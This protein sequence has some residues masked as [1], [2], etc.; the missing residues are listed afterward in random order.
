MAMRRGYAPTLRIPVAEPAS[1]FPKHFVGTWTRVY[2]DRIGPGAKETITGTATFVRDPNI[3]A[4]AEA[5][6]AI[7]CELESASVAWTV[8]GSRVESPCTTTYSG[9]GTDSSAV[10]PFVI[11]GMTLQAVG[12]TYYYSLRVLTNALSAPPFTITLTGNG[13]TSTTQEPIDD[14][15][16]EIGSRSDL[17]PATPPDQ[18]L[19]SADIALLA[20]HRTSAAHGVP[21]DDTWSFTGS[22]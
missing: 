4:T 14:N 9:S 7:P 1:I 3:P 20:G 13:C 6:I 16:L 21:S 10:S 12:G 11:T 19:T 18:L 2:T 22:S 8:A 15:Y 17:N 5:F